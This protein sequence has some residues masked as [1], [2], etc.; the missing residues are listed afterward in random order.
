MAHNQDQPKDSLIATMPINTI[1]TTLT[2]L[3]LLSTNVRQLPCLSIPLILF[4]IMHATCIMIASI[5]I[6][7]YHH[8]CS[9]H[10]DEPLTMTQLYIRP[11]LPP[12]GAL[13]R[14]V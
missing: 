1:D 14:G 5:P 12:M 6:N 13:P 11:G 2:T 8:V 7:I 9:L 10:H 3:I 4:L